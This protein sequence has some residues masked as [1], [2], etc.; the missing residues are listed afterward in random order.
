MVVVLFLFVCVSV[1]V[2]VGSGGCLFFPL[3]F[4]S[5]SSFFLDLLFYLFPEIVAK[6]GQ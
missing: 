2:G 1:V 4:S 6:L 3:V 5:F